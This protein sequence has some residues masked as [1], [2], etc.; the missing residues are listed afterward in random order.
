[1]PSALAVFMLMAGPMRSGLDVSV[2]SKAA[3]TAPK[4]DFRFTPE[5]RLNS[6]IRR[7][8]KGD[9]KRTSPHARSMVDGRYRGKAEVGVGQIDFRVWTRTGHA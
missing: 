5:G 9:T 4:S 3:L 2:G 7:C 1:M 8:P 6:D